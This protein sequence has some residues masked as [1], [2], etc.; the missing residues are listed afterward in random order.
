MQN[1]KYP[2]VAGAF[3]PSDK[4]QLES[5][6]ENF[7][8]KAK[9]KNGKPKALIVPHAGYIYSGPIA[10]NAYI[11]LQKYKDEFDKIVIFSPSHCY[12]FQGIAATD[13]SHFETPLGVIPVSTSDE[14]SVL[15]LE[16]VELLPQAFEKEHALEV[17]LPFLQKVLPGT[18]IVPFIVGQANPEVVQA[19][20]EK[21]DGEK[22]L[23]IISSDLSHF[24]DYETA[25]DVDTRTSSNIESKSFNDIG[26]DDACGYHPLRGMLKWAKEKGATVKIL[27][28]RNSGDTEGSKESV[29]GYGSY[30]IYLD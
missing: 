9:I 19:L 25:V 10:A 14:E 22:T 2:N 21:L 13:S 18:P 24:H 3:Y 11:N 28:L 27:D 26:H 4:D 17:H 6:L 12:A 30:G 7:F 23:F 5:M 1:V 8:A 29:V 16:G 15:S 20:I